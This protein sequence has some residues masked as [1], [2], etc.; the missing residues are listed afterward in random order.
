[1]K[2]EI[3]IDVAI[4]TLDL[5]PYT[6]RIHRCDAVQA[7]IEDYGQKIKKPL[8]KPDN[9]QLY[10][11][12][13][14]GPPPGSATLVIAESTP[15]GEDDVYAMRWTGMIVARYSRFYGKQS[16]HFGMPPE[17]IGYALDIPKNVATVEQLLNNQPIL[18]ALVAREEQEIRQSIE[19][20]NGQLPEPILVTPYLSEA[21][22]I[23]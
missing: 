12:G 19:R 11:Q 22:R 14:T 18:E 5:N 17:E 20:L 7:N 8:Q 13:T 21:L 23:E 15:R 10:L 16:G 6:D 4:M 3:M 2:P 1:M 9:V